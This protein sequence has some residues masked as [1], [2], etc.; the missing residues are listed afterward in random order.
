[1]LGPGLASHS[2][3]GD[4]TGCCHICIGGVAQQHTGQEAVWVQGCWRSRSS[5]S[6]EGQADAAHLWTTRPVS[7]VTAPSR[8][9]PSFFSHSLVLIISQKT[10]V[11]GQ[12][13]SQTEQ[14]NLQEVCFWK[15]EGMTQALDKR[16]NFNN[17]NY[18]YRA[19]TLWQALGRHY[20]SSCSCGRVGINTPPPLYVSKQELR[21]HLPKFPQLIFIESEFESRPF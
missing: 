13:T 19:S 20:L 14:R 15:R 2:S 9:D 8:R 5:Q 4:G 7:A 17:T 11:L 18:A 21:R 12:V 3:L 10:S 6:R 16:I 1:M